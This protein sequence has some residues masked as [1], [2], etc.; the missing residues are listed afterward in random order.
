[1]NFFTPILL[2]SSSKCRPG[3][4]NDCL[5]FSVL[6]RPS[7]QW[8]R[9]VTQRVPSMSKKRKMS[10]LFDHLDS[11]ELAEHLTFLEYKSFCKILVSAS[12]GSTQR[13]T[14]VAVVMDSDPA[15]VAKQSCFVGR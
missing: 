9:Q 12:A 6:P 1:M 14:S 2:H 4:G 5:L 13:F 3:K 11:C 15:I 8:K 10:L 7:Y